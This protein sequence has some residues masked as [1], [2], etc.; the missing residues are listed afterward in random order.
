MTEQ[1]VEQPK[2][3]VNEQHPDAIDLIPAN[4]NPNPSG[5]RYI[6]SSAEAKLDKV[7]FTIIS[8]SGTD[9]KEGLKR[10][11]PGDAIISYD[12]VSPFLMQF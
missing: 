4:P 11:L 5:F 2:E 1:T 3:E 12:G 9:A 10:S 6:V 8:A 7:K